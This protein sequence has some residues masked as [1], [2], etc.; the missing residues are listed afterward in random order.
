MVR[1]RAPGHARMGEIAAR[2]GWS[3]TLRLMASSAPGSSD[4]RAEA[5]ARPPRHPRPTARCPAPSRA[6]APARAGTTAHPPGR[7]D[8]AA[9]VPATRAAGQS[10]GDDDATSPAAHRRDAGAWLMFAG[11]GFVVG[12]IA[13][14]VLLVVV[15]AA[16]GHG[17]QIAQLASRPVPPG[18]GRGDRARRPVVRVRR[19]RRARQPAA[20]DRERASATWASRCAPGTSLVGPAHRAR[21]ASSCCCRCSIS[22]CEHV[23]PHLDQRLKEPAQHLTGGFPGADLAVIAVL[24]VVVV[25]SSRRRSSAASSCG[26]C[27]GSCKGAGPVVGVALAAVADGVIFG[28]AH[29]ELL[30][31]LGPGRVRGGPGPDG[32]Q[33]PAPRA[34]GSSP[35]PRSTCW[36]S[37]R[38]RA[39]CIEPGPSSAGRPDGSRATGVRARAGASGRRGQPKSGPALPLGRPFRARWI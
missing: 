23:V 6:P 13:S 36:R 22:R 2:A 21:R 25:R 30:E 38:W 18:L 5:R 14:A 27:C 12:Q 16:T 15:A 34:R 37:C 19:R 35:T 9:R 29:F 1:A 8:P 20:G 11:L 33:V 26:P 28:L 39:S 7:A 24:T 3:L 4:R 17:S 31:L 32:L 10:G